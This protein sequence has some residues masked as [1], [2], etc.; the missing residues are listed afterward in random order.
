MQITR[1]AHCQ[2]QVAFFV[3]VVVLLKFNFYNF[4][5]LLFGRGPEH[6]H[7]QIHGHIGSIDPHCEVL[8]VAKGKYASLLCIMLPSYYILGQ[9]QEIRLV[10]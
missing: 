10:N 5:A 2:C 8:L 3:V 6:G 7:G 1:W 4:S 9:D